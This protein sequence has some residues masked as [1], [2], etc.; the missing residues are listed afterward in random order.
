MS[1]PGRIRLVEAMGNER[2]AYVC[3]SHCWGRHQLLRTLTSN[4]E[5]HKTKIAWEKL[6]QT[7]KDAIEITRR[8]GVRYIWIDSLC[9]VQDD[10]QDWREEAA[11]MASIYQ[12]S[13]LVIS[14]TRSPDSSGG[15]YTDFPDEFRARTITIPAE[16]TGSDPGEDE[17]VHVRRSL[18]H[19][20][21]LFNSYS[22]QP[23]SLPTL[24]RGWIFQ[25]RFLSPRILHFGPEEL[26]WECLEMSTC[27]CTVD[28]DD[29]KDRS[30]KKY[31]HMIDRAARPKSY[32]NFP[33][34]RDT[35]SLSDTGLMTCWHHLVEDYTQL[36]LTYEKDIFPAVAGLARQMQLARQKSPTSGQYAAGLWADTLAM[37]LLWY[38]IDP[39]PSL[40]LQGTP[41]GQ[42]SE[43]EDD[44][45][46]WTKRPASWRAPTWSWASVLAPVKFIDVSPS[47][48]HTFEPCCEV[49]NVCCRPAGPDPMG[50]LMPPVTALADNS[51]T[52][53]RQNSVQ[54]NSY[55]TLKG[56]LIS[57]ELRLK[58]EPTNHRGVKFS[59]PKPWT[60]VELG[61][62]QGHTTNVWADDGCSGLFELPSSSSSFLTNGGSCAA[63]ES[64]PC[65]LLHI[66][67]KRPSRHGSSP[68]LYFLILATTPGNVDSG[69]EPS[70]TTTRIVHRRIGLAEVFGGP[71]GKG[72]DA[73]VDEL[74][75]KVEDGLVEGGSIITVV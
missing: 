68:T 1:G 13:F 58:P 71:P 26:S 6:P 17:K 3:L 62:L 47:P 45:R 23:A 49:L 7:F 42:P 56:R 53:K 10:Q 21:G 66:G 15:L 9:I 55:I 24:K 4:L 51:T 64:V 37:D 52:E 72:S 61:V 12:G 31:K 19:P 75:A 2:E 33:R 14:A 29:D 8:L 60:M 39:T 25:E 65:F 67:R 40:S 28:D 11:K 5:S 20:K 57:T 27:Q 69:S 59:R 73:W 32:Y 16:R 30:N 18:T 54:Y 63:R 50:E 38:V 43:N 35:L 41:S 36:L 22:A 48:A 74:L 34:W 70:S 44:I 46:D